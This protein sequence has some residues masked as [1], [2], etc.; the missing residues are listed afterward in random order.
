MTDIWQTKLAARLHDPAEKALILLRDP[1]GHENGTSLALSR[2]LGLREVSGDQIDHDNDEVLARTL[3]KHS[4]PRA[5][6]ETVR[7][8]DWWAAAADRPQ[9]P[10][11]EITVQTRAGEPRKLKVADWA[12]V[13]WTKSPQLV[14]PL[15]GETVDLGSLVD[16]EVEDIKQRAFEHFSGLLRALGPTDADAP[17]DWRRIAL[18][19]WRFGSELSEEADNGKLGELWPMLPAD[20]RVPDHSIWEHLD[21]TSAFAGAF[22]GD[23]N[24][25]AALLTVSIGPVQPFIAAARKLDD[26]WAGSHLLSRLAWETMRPIAEALGPDAILFPRLRGIAQVDLWLRD[27]KGLPD[28]LFAGAPWKERAT[29]A[30]PLFAAALPNRFV[31]VVPASQARE[32]AERCGDAAREWIQDRGREVV[33]ELLGVADLPDR[34]DCPAYAQA[35]EQLAGFPEVHWAAVPFSLIRC[36]DPDK[37]R[38]LDPSGLLAAMAPFHGVAEGQPCGFFD[39]PAWKV[40]AKTIEAEDG[41]RPITFFAPNPGVLY[42]AVYDL[43]ERVLAAAKSVRPFDALEQQGWRDSLT[44][45]TEWL[46]HDRAQL[47]LPQGAR[48]DTLW[49]RIADRKPAWARKG[50][51]LGALSAIKRLWPTLFARE[52]AAAIGEADVGR[53]TVSTHT[54][55]LAGQLEMLNKK[56]AEKPDGRLAQIL[57][58]ARGDAPALPRKL[59]RLR[60][61]QAARFLTAL[62]D[63]AESKT[64]GEVEKL[65]AAFKAD[66]GVG[67]ETYYGLLMMDGDRM[68][69]ILSGDPEAKT[70][71]TYRDSFHEKVRVGVARIA[72][73]SPQLKAYL[74]QERAVSPGRHLAISAALNDFSQHVARHVVETEYRGRLIYAGGDDVLA[75]LPVADLIDCAA[76]LRQAYSGTLPEDASTD[77]GELRKTRFGLHC[78]NGYAWL[79]GRLMRMM[80]R[81]ATAS[82]GLVVAHHQ[83]PLGA[84]MRE[85]RATEKRAK[86]D[87]GR[88]ALAIKVIKRSGGALT[89]WLKWPEVAL[90]EELVGFLRR[91]STSRRAVYHSLSWLD[92]LPDPSTDPALLGALLRYQ[93]ERQSKG[94]VPTELPQSLVGWA[95]RRPTGAKDALGALL[96]VA[97]FLAR[98]VRSEPVEPSRGANGNK[99]EAA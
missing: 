50:E 26:L 84:V 82:A 9:W 87:G 21:L 67:A 54:M 94:Q 86:R 33:R 39:T 45:E 40:L 53:F 83:A 36:R 85:L 24:G 80:G 31:A 46:T 41:G 72:E 30:N 76:R 52:V 29:D 27:A 71:I 61:S 5:I 98:E 90:L 49:T 95:I 22:A 56:L 19:Y 34:E 48:A 35:R 88:D 70:A 16:T 15:T 65:R 17:P 10:M 79:R 7:R 78:K 93:F 2:L 92:D 75:V 96:S 64:E 12:Q 18:A 4:L 57:T 91:E 68:G 43:A 32:L 3:F 60:K 55:A 6:Y 20:T 77:W 42:P 37:Q 89:L 59:S 58:E 62:E 28:A 81:H 13:R 14:H 1:E 66:T 97:E 44:G 69:A 38:D 51:H 74:A 8:A 99:K 23:P 73:H 47:D 63:A 11:E 25:E